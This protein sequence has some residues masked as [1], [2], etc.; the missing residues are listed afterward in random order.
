MNKNILSFVLALS[1]V[2]VLISSC[3]K[4]DPNE[5]TNDLLNGTW[6]AT[7]FITD[8]NVERLT[9]DI[10]K[11]SLVFQKDSIDG[12]LL[13]WDI[14]TRLVTLD[15]WSGRYS[16]Y[17]S[18]TRISFSDKTFSVTFEGDLL[19]MSLLNDDSPFDIVAEKN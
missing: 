14:I 19:K 6:Q 9:G 3:T 11:N 18:G 15:D 4:S 1:T 13:T 10:T 8:D 17:N 12:G 2:L 7:S 5:E 16:V